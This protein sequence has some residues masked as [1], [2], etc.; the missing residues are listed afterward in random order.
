MTI[1]H[2]IYLADSRN[3][4]RGQRLANAAS[5]NLVLFLSSGRNKRARARARM[6][7]DVEKGQR[8][9]VLNPT[10]FRD[11]QDSKRGERDFADNEMPRRNVK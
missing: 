1:N 2:F 8:P 10:N 9:C 3:T 4:E 11:F 6:T 5:E 7:R